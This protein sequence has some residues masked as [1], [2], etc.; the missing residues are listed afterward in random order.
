MGLGKN[1]C[2]ELKTIRNAIA[3]AN[4]IDYHSED[5]HFGGEC[6]GTC[7][8]CESEIRRLEDELRHRMSLGKRVVLSGLAI[9][10]TAVASEA[11]VNDIVSDSVCNVVKCGALVS[12]DTLVEGGEVAT[13]GDGSDETIDGE[14]VYLLVDDMPRFI[15][16][17]ESALM[18]YVL[19]NIRIPA[20]TGEVT[21]SEYYFRILVS[22]VV[23]KSGSIASVRVHRSSE[24]APFDKAVV[25]V[26]RTMPD[27]IPGRLDGKCVN[28]RYTL[29]ISVHVRY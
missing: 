22:F 1:I 19:S 11:Q 21:P 13:W 12:T 7:P 4:D 29:P 6:I 20:L 14:P 25:D 18:K 26:I 9:G 3:D 16:S 15:D 8:R 5:C 2:D 17:S 27:W 28:V 10:I 23:T 24:Y